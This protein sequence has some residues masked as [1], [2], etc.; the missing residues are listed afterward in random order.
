MT[1]KVD[2]P[3]SFSHLN[4]ETEKLINQQLSFDWIKS[5]TKPAQIDNHLLT[6][7]GKTYYQR[8][9]DGNCDNGNCT[10]NCACGDHN[11]TDCTISAIN[12][13]NCDT[14]KLLQTD[15]NAGSV[16]VYNCTTNQVSINCDCACTICA[17]SVVC[18]CW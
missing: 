8:Y 5:V 6:Y 4:V 11:C 10:S 16:P 13:S 7:L 17:C 3:L 2:A 12:C 1:L 9:M 18:A 14:Q 15:C